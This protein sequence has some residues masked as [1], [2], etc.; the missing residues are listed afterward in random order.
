MAAFVSA[1]CC[2]RSPLQSNKIFIFGLGYVGLQCALHFREQGWHV[3][4][5]TRSSQSA[6]KAAEKSI[7][8]ISADESQPS[9]LHDFLSH[10][11]SEAT[12]LLSTA[13]PTNG[14]DSVLS[15]F[16]PEVNK[17]T[18]LVWIVSKSLCLLPA[19]LRMPKKHP[20]LTLVIAYLFENSRDIYQAQASMVSM[21]VNGWTRPPYLTVPQQ[22][23][24]LVF[25]RRANGQCMQAREKSQHISFGLQVS[26]VRIEVPYTGYSEIP[27]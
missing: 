23:V 3:A 7:A 18:R 21:T 4:G 12:H 20:G 14:A 17:A 22:R 5:L 19:A 9:L 8:A 26:T 25:T 15:A 10:H 2:S 13:P 6:R 24:R 1:V 11:L 27:K 16:E